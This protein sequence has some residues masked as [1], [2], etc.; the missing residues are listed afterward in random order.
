MKLLIGIVT[1]SLEKTYYRLEKRYVKNKI[2][3][4]EK[5]LVFILSLNLI[6]LSRITI[7]FIKS[8]PNLIIT[9]ICVKKN[10]NIFEYLPIIA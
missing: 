5:I 10:T 4:I 2:E 7:P 9:K 3:F 8:F 1:L 6:D